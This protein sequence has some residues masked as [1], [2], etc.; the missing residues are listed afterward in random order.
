MKSK[1]EIS[2]LVFYHN[3]HYDIKDYINKK[4]TSS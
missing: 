2:N 3:I 1:E 4:T